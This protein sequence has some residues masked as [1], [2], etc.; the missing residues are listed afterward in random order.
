[1]ELRCHREL[2]LDLHQVLDEQH[3]R[4]SSSKVHHRRDL[5][6]R[7]GGDHAEASAGQSRPA[8]ALPTYVIE[9]LQR[10]ATRVRETIAPLPTVDDVTSLENA[11]DSLAAS[12]DRARSGTSR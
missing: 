8:G 2:I 7:L 1:M 4:K 6:R 11:L 9:E 5:A 3:Q 12:I 10:E